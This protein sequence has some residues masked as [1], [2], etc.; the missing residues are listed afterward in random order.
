ML[1]MQAHAG[2]SGQNKLKKL[3]N[4]SAHVYQNMLPRPPKKEKVTKL[5]KGPHFHP[6]MR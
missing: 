4:K 1:N 6:E 5:E 3:R 2:D